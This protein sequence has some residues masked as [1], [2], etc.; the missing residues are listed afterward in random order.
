MRYVVID[1]NAT[2]GARTI[3]GHRGRVI[4]VFKTP[5]PA[6]SYAHHRI[7]KGDVF[8]VVVDQITG[9]QVYPALDPRA[10][11][12]PPPKYSGMVRVVSGVPTQ[13]EDLKPP[14]EEPKPPKEPVD[15]PKRR[16]PAS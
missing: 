15:P 9:E 12:E 7:S 2:T 14:K 10:P 11:S 1:L 5:R 13:K 6:R 16:K 8:V 3:A 4:G